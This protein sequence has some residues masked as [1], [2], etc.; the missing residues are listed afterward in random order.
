MIQFDYAMTNIFSK[1]VCNHPLATSWPPK[2]NTSGVFF[3]WS[4]NDRSGEPGVLSCVCEMMIDFLQFFHIGFPSKKSKHE[5]INQSQA[6]NAKTGVLKNLPYSNLCGF[7]AVRKFGDWHGKLPV[8]PYAS[9]DRH[10]PLGQVPSGNLKYGECKGNRRQKMSGKFLGW[11]RLFTQIISNNYRIAI[12]TIIRKN[13][14]PVFF[15]QCLPRIGEV[16]HESNK[17][18]K[19]P[20]KIS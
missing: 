19:L 2:K 8:I 14:P 12:P 6:E 7:V 20:S 1:W 3:E 17:L 16:H 18:P 11:W 13:Y 5:Y 9:A 10:E 15:K 4:N